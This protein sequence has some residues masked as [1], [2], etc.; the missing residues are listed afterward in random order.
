MLASVSSTA[1]PP[2]WCSEQSGRAFKQDALTDS[3]ICRL[4]SRITVG[5]SAD[6]AAAYPSQRMARL[7]VT[8]RGGRR[9]SHF[10]KTR[11][12]DPED[13]LTDADLIGKFVELAGVGFGTRQH[14][15]PDADDTPFR[16]PAWF[17]S[18]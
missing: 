11:K 3:R 4:M 13:P 10:Q 14:R 2:S 12:G 16:S 7:E 9:I 15:R 6:L 8:L 17:G 1:L 5:E 18:V